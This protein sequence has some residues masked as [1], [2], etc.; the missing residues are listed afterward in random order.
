MKK[1]QFSNTGI[2]VSR[3]CLG[4]MNFGQQCDEVNAHAQLDYA[5]SR[6]ISMIDT[7][8]VYP[9][10]P[11]KSKQGNTE[12]MIGNWI[13]KRK[14]RD[15][16]FLASKVSARGM[17]SFIGRRDASAGLTKQSI[18]AAIDGTLERLQTDFIDLYQVHFPDRQMNNNGVRG[19]QSLTDDDGASIEE[20][21]AGLD[22]VVKSGKVRYIGVS[23]ESPWGVMEY[24]RVAREKGYA[25][26][27]S[28]QNQYS[29]T[30][31]TFEIGLS[32]MCMRES[33]AFLPYS[34]LNM[35]VLTGK[36]LNGAEPAGARFSGTGRNRPRYN[37]AHDEAQ[38]AFAAYVALEQE[39]GLKPGQLAIAFA[40]SRAFTTSV[41]L[42]ATSVEQLA[43]NIDAGD[44]VLTDAMMQR[45][46][47]LYTRMPDPTC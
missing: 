29:L 20:T 10:P 37:P 11:D 5:I 34:V 27:T 7:A 9:I 12:I 46:T 31:R 1:T 47:D 21:L 35:G 19:V 17:A 26:I 18:I 16:F 3:L 41:I 14:K 30:N 8:E 25:R 22:A 28:I 44:V 43:T 4:T 6:G 15:D 38:R 23:N 33:I 42:G 36:Y 13:A 24:L 40:A 2:E 32:E 45:V 39:F